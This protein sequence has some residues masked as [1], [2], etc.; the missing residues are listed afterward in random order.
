MSSAAVAAE[1]AKKRP[2]LLRRYLTT[3]LVWNPAITV[4]LTLA[5]SSGR[6][7]FLTYVVSLTISEVVCTVCF[8][9]VAAVRRKLPETKLLFIAI[10]PSLARWKLA[11]KQREA[12][13]L[14]AEYSKSE[15]GL[16][17]LDVFAPMLGTDGA[18]RPEL[19]VKDG[20]HLSPEGY[21]LWV[22]L[23]APFLDKPEPATPRKGPGGA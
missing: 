8:G 23:L 5:F 9:F 15:Q 4:G 11:D 17:Y 20:L 14:I 18:P 2:T 12:N 22:S 21:K 7:S 3:I 19:F 10:K 16:L 13:R 6:P 1:Q